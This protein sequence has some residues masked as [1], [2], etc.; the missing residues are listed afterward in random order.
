M[1]VFLAKLL[2]G[3]GALA[4]CLIVLAAIVWGI[5]ELYIKL[6][7]CDFD[8]RWI[9][10]FIAILCICFLFAAYYLGSYLLA[11]HLQ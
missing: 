4:L 9:I 11:G 1:T 7:E 3:V 5:V 6:I 2:V 8:S 10:D